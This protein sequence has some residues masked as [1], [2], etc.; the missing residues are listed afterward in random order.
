MNSLMGCPIVS[1]FS[2][3]WQQNL[4]AFLDYNPCYN[5]TDN[6]GTCTE[7]ACLLKQVPIYYTGLGEIIKKNT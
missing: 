7:K 5:Y 1:I 3:Q 6:T 4:C 2:A